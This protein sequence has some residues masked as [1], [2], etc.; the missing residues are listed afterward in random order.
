M[1][2]IVKTPIKYE[3]KR[4]EIGDVVEIYKKDEEVLSKYGDI[5]KDKK[6]NGGKKGNKGNKTENKKEGK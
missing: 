3:G 4:R 1:K 5:I 2:L 6:A